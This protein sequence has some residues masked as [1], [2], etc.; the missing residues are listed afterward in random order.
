MYNQYQ[1]IKNKLKLQASIEIC[2][3]ITRPIIITNV[4]VDLRSRDMRSGVNL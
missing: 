1:D 4:L 2:K 3:D